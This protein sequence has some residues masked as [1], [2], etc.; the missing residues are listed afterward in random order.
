M[1]VALVA[2]LALAGM[3]L[4][5]RRD[6]GRGLE[7]FL[8]GRVLGVDGGDLLLTV[9]VA[10]GVW[11]VL[12]LT[13]RTLVAATFDPDAARAAG[14][15][16]RATDIALVGALA[17]VVVVALSAVGSLLTLALLVTPAVSARLLVDRMVATVVVAAVI[18]AASGV[19]GLVISYW[20]GVASGGA[21]VLV[22]SG[23]FAVALLLGPRGLL[24][25]ALVPRQRQALQRP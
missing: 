15:P 10:I 9:G 7:S 18:G 24:G 14:L 23:T 8:F 11:C 12:L 22:A 4:S 5:Q 16:V 20:W 1:G 13:W 3:I 17:A 6:I 21:V 25:R 19:G 2:A